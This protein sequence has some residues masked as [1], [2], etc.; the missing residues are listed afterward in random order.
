MLILFVV[1]GHAVGGIYHFAGGHAR[2][3][4]GIVFKAIYL[5]HMPAFFFVAGYLWRRH[6]DR[7]L[8]TCLS[9]HVR[10]LVVPYLIWGFASA[11]VFVTLVA[12]SNIRLHG[13][14]GYYGA[15]MFDFPIWRP[16]VSILH[17]GDWPNGEG[18][19]CNSVLWFLPCMFIVLAVYDCLDRLLCSTGN[20]RYHTFF[21]V[22]L[23]VVCAVI[24]ALLRFKKFSFLPW[25]LS[26]A[27]FFLVFF[28]FG[29]LIPKASCDRSMHVGWWMVFCG[30]LIIVLAAWLY[31]DL[32]CAYVSWGWFIYSMALAAL[33]C[34]LSMWTAEYFASERCADILSPLGV[35]SLGIMLLHK[36]LMM[37][38][39]GLCSKLP[40]NSVFFVVLE[41][42]SMTS[43]AVIIS[44]FLSRI[45]R[46]RIPCVLGESKSE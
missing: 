17:A 37:P 34:I 20:R 35:S 32:G 10:R 6:E 26:R 30:W 11:L 41:T 24:A 1:L 36:F 23:V 9:K 19:R 28:A 44:E 13:Y 46:K 42:I 5:F 38:L 16:F 21:N 29:Q 12:L 40:C 4:L 45:I 33:G 18:F 15:R 7:A 3:A 27:P 8:C 39:L 31:P 22:S 2:I 14:D 43:L 25:G